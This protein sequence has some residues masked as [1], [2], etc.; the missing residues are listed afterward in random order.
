M[1][2]KRVFARGPVIVG[3][4]GLGRGTVD[5]HLENT[6]ESFLAAAPAGVDWVEVD[7]RRT[8]DD[9]LVV[10]HN[11]ADADGVFYAD[12]TAQEACD[13]GALRLGELLEALPESVGVDFDVKTSMEDATLARTRT[14]MGRLAAVAARE[15]RRRD[16]LV[17][18]F[19]PGGLDIARQLAPGVARG[20]LTWV[21]FP[22]GHAVAAAGHLDVQVLAPHWGSMHPNDAE[23]RPLHR[24]LDY[25]IDLVH[26]SGRELLA[27]CPEVEFAQRL[28]D[29][30]ADALCVDDVPTV[31][32]SLKAPASA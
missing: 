15:S 31:V 24:P 20:L 25:V 26:A 32:A 1:D 21:G 30:G 18:S 29:A 5:G 9:E 2:G 7:V 3:H 27:W 8:V 23:P 4:R 17:T 22:I 11:P 12:I 6:L 10:V 13:K 28:L 19:D 14:T 16:V